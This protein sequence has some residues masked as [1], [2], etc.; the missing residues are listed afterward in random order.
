MES[1]KRDIAAGEATRS[2]AADALASS[3]RAISNVNRNLHDLDTQ[4]SSTQAQL[5][6][7]NR[8]HAAIDESVASQR[9]Q[10][11][12]MLH[13][14][15]LAGSPDPYKLLL[16]G[17]D[18]N[19]IL[20]ERQYLGYVSDA[21]ALVLNSLRGDLTRLASLSDQAQTHNAQL[22]EISGQQEAQRVD[23]LKDEQARRA[24]LAQISQK[25][26][27]Q[28]A[29]AGAMER[30]EKHLS[31]VVSKLGLLIERQAREAREREQQRARQLEQA[32]KEESASTAGKKETR[33]APPEHTE[34]RS[35]P[36]FS[37]NFLALRG[38]MRLP[39]N[40][41]LTGRFGTSRAAGGPTWKGL[42]IRAA[43]GSPV[44]AIAPGRVV[45]AEW[46]RG[47]G[48]LLILDHGNQYLSI[49]GNNQALLKKTG[50]VVQAGDVIATVGNSGG[51]SQTGLYFEMRYQGR[52]FDPLAW[53]GPH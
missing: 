16:S 18:P 10:L 30:D 50:D 1:L 22:T 4:R 52:P 34:P 21:E 42:F 46:L 13:D 28:R 40:G 31:E 5:D 20:R 36:P 41:E 27:V 45:F 23:L 2:E 39:V 49:Y 15:Y 43:E 48:N 37:G 17:D 53:T 6:D 35:E 12:Q 9:A 38:K 51:N 24:T 11:A 33:E 19:R 44:R 25:L 7:I 32:R 26:L 29:Q 47:F 14:Q 8:Q 3:E